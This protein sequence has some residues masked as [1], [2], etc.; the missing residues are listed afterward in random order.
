MSNK[1]IIIIAMLLGCCTAAAE[2]KQA[3]QTKPDTKTHSAWRTIDGKQCWYR[4]HRGL[5]RE[6][7]Y[8]TG[9]TRKQTTR[10]AR[11]HKAPE[12]AVPLPPSRPPVATE[13]L[14]EDL[15]DRLNY[16]FAV[17]SSQT[18]Q[19]PSGALPL[20]MA[21]PWLGRPIPPGLGPVPEPP[22]DWVVIPKTEPRPTKTKRFWDWLSSW[23][24]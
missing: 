21:G 23:W 7:L 14:S 18:L 9:H 1:L 20:A 19:T 12:E 5:A 22:S 13:P 11:H 24:R 8:W 6:N 2:A 10:V 17:L 3:C 16:Y 15:T 4:G